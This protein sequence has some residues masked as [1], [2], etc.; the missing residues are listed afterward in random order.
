MAMTL[1]LDGGHDNFS[2][3]RSSSSSSSSSRGVEL[4]EDLDEDDDD[5][6]D[7]D[8]VAWDNGGDE[9]SGPNDLKLSEARSGPSFF[10]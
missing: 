4:H 3:S 6:D 10:P 7:D 1:G 8:V 9:W 2:A 5:D